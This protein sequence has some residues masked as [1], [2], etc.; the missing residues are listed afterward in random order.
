[1]AAWMHGL[2][3]AASSQV[4]PRPGM[5]GAAHITSLP[6]KGP[7]YARTEAVLLV[8]RLPGSSIFP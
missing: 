5:G 6:M 2:K 4:A 3:R 8:A 1:M 7:H